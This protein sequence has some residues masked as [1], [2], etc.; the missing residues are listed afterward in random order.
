MWLT[1]FYARFVWVD[2]VMAKGNLRN[3]KP[4]DKFRAQ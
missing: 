3:L 1:A 4:K 2:S